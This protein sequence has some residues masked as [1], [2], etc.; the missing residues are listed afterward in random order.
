MLLE[1]VM[2]VLN[3][4]MVG[5]LG[6]MQLSAV[7]LGTLSV[8]FSTFLFSFL[9]F[10]TVPEIAAAVV[11][12]DD[13]QVSCIAAKSLWIAGVAGVATMGLLA[14]CAGP[15]IAAMNPPEAAVAA[16]AVD[17]IRVR[18]LGVPA[19]LLGFVA[20][21]VFRG[22]KDTRTP[23]LAAGVSATASLGLNVLFLYGFNWGVV[24]SG[25]AT[26][27]A[28][29]ISCALLVG[30]LFRGGKVQTR[31]ML[32]PPP[33]ATVLPTLR[34]GAAL[35]T[36]NI[37]AMG[38]VLYASALCIR[39][40]SVHQAS[41]EIIRQVWVLTIQFFECLNVAAQALCATYLGN[42]DRATARDLLGRL[43]VLGTAVGAA[44]GVAVWALQDPL[45]AIF[46]SDP[47]VKAHALAALPM[48]CVLFPLDAVASI[49]DGSL[50]AAKQ[51]NYLSVVQI[52]GSI[53][54]YAMLVALAPAGMVSTYTVWAALKI[55][56]FV[57]ALGGAYRDYH[58]PRSAY[59]VPATAV[60]VPTAATAA[61]DVALAALP[62]AA[63]SAVES[64]VGRAAAG[65]PS[66]SQ[67]LMPGVLQS[68]EE[69]VMCLAAA[70]ATS[71]TDI[72]P[73]MIDS[74]VSSH[75]SRPG[76]SSSAVHHTD[77]NG[78]TAPGGAAP[79]SSGNG[80]GNGAEGHNG[81]GHNGNGH[82]I[83]GHSA[84]GH[85]VHVANGHNGSTNGHNGW[86]LE[87]RDLIEV[88]YDA[89]NGTRLSGSKDGAGGGAGGQVAVVAAAVADSSAPL[90]G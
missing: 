20:T 68:Y 67:R 77:G 2:N 15:I 46:T 28:Q 4:G 53:I 58:S 8:S 48:I 70:A 85:G 26:T 61:A 66:T 64:A 80:N 82:G 29:I 65:E 37:I 38:M 60:P 9:L 47:V 72:N 59:L 74:L 10:L 42:E 27:C 86:V 62:V 44:S 11:K 78:S 71:A 52:A 51:S 16:Y 23:L 40:G 24:G 84:N 1:P 43:L 30:S 21:G 55:M 34:L 31:H 88:R 36:R 49:L 35:G 89:A 13:E 14:A 22:F 5:H 50:L 57:R 69:D 12:K 63:A 83:N 56:T 75:A 18:A 41:F 54:Q 17:F 76:P 3:A 39:M 90:A 45:I 19:V 79:S 87:G 7:S 6:T 73:D 81:S 32:R 25:L 33:L